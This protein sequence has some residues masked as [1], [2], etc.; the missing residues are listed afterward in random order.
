MDGRMDGSQHRFIPPYHMPARLRSKRS[1]G[2]IS[3]GLL[4]W[5]SCSHACASVTK[6]YYLVLAYGRWRSSAGKVT[7]SLARSSGSLPPGGWLKVT[8]GLTAW[9]PG[10][11]PGP[12]LGNECGRTLPFYHKAGSKIATWDLLLLDGGIQSFLGLELFTQLR[13]HR[14]QTHRFLHVTTQLRLHT[15]TINTIC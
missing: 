7:T 14:S 2:Q 15:T 6:H 10:S 13:H 11:A 4:P 1:R 5:A 8:C 12:M 3:A 9:T